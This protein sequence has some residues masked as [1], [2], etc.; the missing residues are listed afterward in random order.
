MNQEEFTEEQSN[1]AIE[2]SEN[3]NNNAAEKQNPSTLSSSNDVILIEDE[4]DDGDPLPKRACDQD[5]LVN[6]NRNI[7]HR[8]ND[9][10]NHGSNGS[11]A[12]KEMQQISSFAY[13]LQKRS[14]LIQSNQEDGL[15]DSYD[16]YEQ[17]LRAKE[18]NRSLVWR[19]RFREMG[20][21][22][23]RGNCMC[24]RNHI[25]GRLLQIRRYGVCHCNCSRR[26]FE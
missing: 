19:T 22:S 4:E 7:L 1:K 12:D 17:Y 15:F 3:S 13:V 9:S 8:S 6:N 18:F 25:P 21:T 24:N 20:D 11:D 10:N 5:G 16:E 14:Q 23:F 26:N 2:V